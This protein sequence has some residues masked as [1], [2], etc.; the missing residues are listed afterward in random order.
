MSEQLI[1]VYNLVFGS[2]IGSLNKVWSSSGVCWIDP[3]DREL[4]VVP[5][6][7]VRGPVGAELAW[8]WMGSAGPRLE[9]P[10][11][12][13]RNPRTGVPLKHALTLRLPVPYQR[14]G[15]GL[16]GIAYFVEVDEYLAMPANG[17]VCLADSIIPQQY[18]R[19]ETRQGDAG[20]AYAMLWLTE[21]ELSGGPATCP[22]DISRLGTPTCFD[23]AGPK[24]GRTL[25]WWEHVAMLQWVW[26]V[27]RIGDIN[28]GV[29]PS[30]YDDSPYRDPWD[31]ADQLTGVFVCDDHLGGTTYAGGATGLPDGMTPYYLELATPTLDHDYGNHETH[32]IDLESRTFAIC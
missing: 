17:D 31:C 18:P 16:P 28:A 20:D 22:Q 25:S 3:P 2:S 14:R 30:S 10:W 19:L 5:P 26:L 21:G 8:G 15:P 6:L 7:P 11:V 1:P 32:L 24:R 12:W 23:D 27:E 29:A 4:L 13:P 9:R